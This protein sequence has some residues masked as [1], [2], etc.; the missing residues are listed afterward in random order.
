MTQLETHKPNSS[1]VRIPGA[2]QQQHRRH[3][4]HRQQQSNYRLLNSRSRGG[5][6]GL[7]D[8]SSGGTGRAGGPYFEH[9]PYDAQTG[10][11]GRNLTTVEGGRA[12]LACVIRNLGR[13]STVSAGGSV[14][15]RR[16]KFGKI[17]DIITN[18]RAVVK[19]AGL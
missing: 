7:H 11:G 17:S 1:P 15:K 8:R 12:V 5:G 14:L 9:I 2:Q 3:Q 13:N 19:T 10:E 16:R 6:G 4:S 18:V